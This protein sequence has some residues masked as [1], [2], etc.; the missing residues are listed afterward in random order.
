M[1]RVNRQQ[2]G[3]TQSRPLPQPAGRQGLV[4]AEPLSLRTALLQVAILLG[5]PL[6]L[7]VV[8][9]VILRTFFPELGY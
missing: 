4:P 7:L 1:S 8:A 2:Q 3:P 9:R 5:I 6:F